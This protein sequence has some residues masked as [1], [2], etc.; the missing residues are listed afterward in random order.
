ME[1]SVKITLIICTTVLIMAGVAL[2]HEEYKD[3]K[4][5]RREEKRRAQK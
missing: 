2:I 3:W 4:Y 5:W 1:P